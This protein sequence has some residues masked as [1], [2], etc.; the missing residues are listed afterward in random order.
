M[1][2]SQRSEEDVCYALY[3]CDNDVHKAVI[4]LLET[5]EVDAFAT[6]SKKKKNR[7]AAP[8][9]T[10]EEW[11]E[12]NNGGPVGRDNDNRDRSRGRGGFRGGNRAGDRDRGGSRPAREFRDRDGDSRGNGRSYGGDRDKEEYRGG[13][14]N[15]VRGTGRGGGFVSRGGRGGRM[16]GPR[17]DGR[18]GGRE[19]SHRNNF[20]RGQQDTQEIDA[21]DASQVTAPDMQHNKSEDTW[22]DW[23]N[24]EYTGSLNDTKVFTPSTQGQGSLSSK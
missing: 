3:E 5:L 21:W 23:D 24:E 17:A 22:G 18:P 8:E 7:S 4:Y 12:N 16:G 13:R 11:S 15:G 14:N 19:N 9:A 10:D 1:E 2:M 6:T 20:S